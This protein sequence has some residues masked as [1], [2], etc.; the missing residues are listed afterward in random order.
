MSTVGIVIALI[1]CIIG[2]VPFM[3]GFKQFHKYSL[4][5]DTPR[6]KIRSMAIGLVEIH[7]NVMAKETILT[8]FSQSQCVYY[9]YE[10]QEYRR[11]VRS[12][13]KGRVTVTYSWDT[14]ATGSRRIPFFAR[15]ETGNVYVNPRGAEYNVPLKKSFY[16]RGGFLRSLS[17]ILS[18]LSDWDN[19]KTNQIN[20]GGWGLEPIQPGRFRW[21]ASV[22]DRK[23][24]EHYL[25]PEENLFLMGTATPDHNAPN[26][27][28]VKKGENEPTFII[29]NRSE[30]KVMGSLKWQMIGLLILASILEIIGVIVALFAVDAID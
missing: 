25:A 5:K 29:S 23:Y 3:F 28:L 1:I 13:G 24:H 6:S 15:D 11:H 2:A 18:A 7:G 26:N 19:A 27:V 17:P 30:T 20:T 4:I 9:Y 8:P 16:Q 14:I 21:G 12:S 22:G 10:I